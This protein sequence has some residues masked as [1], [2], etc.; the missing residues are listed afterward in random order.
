MRPIDGTNAEFQRLPGGQTGHTG[1]GFFFSPT[2]DYLA[3]LGSAKGLME[4]VSFPGLKQVGRWRWKDTDQVFAKWSPTEKQLILDGYAYSDPS[5]LS[6]RSLF[7][8]TLP[9]TLSTSPTP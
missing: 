1:D 4:I 6:A 5:Q 2:G 3:I 9:T 7:L 8:V